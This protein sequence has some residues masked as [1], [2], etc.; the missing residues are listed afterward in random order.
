LLRAA[1]RATI[2]FVRKQAARQLLVTSALCG[3]VIA[4]FY[5]L[6][7]FASGDPFAFLGMLMPVLVALPFYVLLTAF[8]AYAGVRWVVPPVPP[9]IPLSAINVATMFWLASPFFAPPQPIEHDSEFGAVC[10]Q[11]G[12]IEGGCH[13][14]RFTFW[15]AVT[16][17]LIS[18]A[19]ATAALW[20]YRLKATDGTRP[21]P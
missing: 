21:T 13:S 10:W 19:L 16:A 7:L 8:I 18:T 11:M 3:V 17:S 2:L 4:L 6:I 12:G 5:L 1:E 14:P 15:C 9:A 20:G